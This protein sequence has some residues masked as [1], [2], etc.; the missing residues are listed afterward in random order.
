MMQ[1]GYEVEEARRRL[2]Q[3]GGFVRR[4]LTKQ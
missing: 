1:G 2:E 3:A 4:A